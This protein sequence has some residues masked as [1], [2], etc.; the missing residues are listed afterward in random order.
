MFGD[1]TDEM[2]IAREEVFGTVI[3]VLAYDDPDEIA[4]RANGLEYGLAAS[5]WTDDLST[6][7]RLAAGIRAGAVFINMIHVPDA[8]TSWGREMGP[9]AIDAHTEVTGV[10][11]HLGGA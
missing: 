5:I 10:W 9:Y 6:A 3:P 11:T 8:A 1:V 4:G 7:H 2:A